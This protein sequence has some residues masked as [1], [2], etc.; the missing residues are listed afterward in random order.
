MGRGA[1]P[2]LP[3]LNIPYNGVPSMSKGY[4][5]VALMLSVEN[6]CNK[7]FMKIYG[8]IS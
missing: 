4:H 2:D 7:I 8:H 6:K 5:V 3:A 1:T